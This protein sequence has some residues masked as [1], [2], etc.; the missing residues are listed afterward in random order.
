MS[1]VMEGM[2]HFARE[3]VDRR[4]IRDLVDA[5]AHYADQR[6]PSEQAALFTADGT[7]SVYTGDPAS[8]EAAQCLRGHAE[9]ADSFKIL[10]NYEITTHFNGQSTITLDG[11]RASG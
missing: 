7:V 9:L 8:T 2:N 10:D 4:T 3:A 5:W 11:D 6:R 1:T